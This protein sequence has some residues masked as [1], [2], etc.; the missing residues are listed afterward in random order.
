VKKVGLILI[1][2]LIVFT[3]NTFSRTTENS[4][5]AVSQEHVQERETHDEAEEH[6]E[7]IVHI[8]TR[9]VLQLVLIL[10]AAKIA[11]E[12]CERYLKQPGVLGELIAGMIIG[13][14]VLGSKIIIPGLGALFASPQ[15]GVTIPVSNELYALGQIAVIILLFMAGL[16]TDFKQFFKYAGPATVVAIGGV[17]F[18]FV[19]GAAATIFFIHDIH[20]ITHPEALFVG[21]IMVATSVGIT[22]RILS[23]IN[24][25]DT[26]EGVTI[27][28]GAVVDDVL[29][30][31]ILAI[32]VGVS[33]GEGGITGGT[34]ALIAIKAVGIWIGI[35][36]MG[37][38]LSKQIERFLLWF[39]NEGALLALGLAFC[40]LAAGIAELFGL[41]AIIGSYA[42]GLAL[43]EREIS[44]R[45][46]K[47]LTP[48]FDFLVPV[49]FVVM[50]MLV[51]FS[52][53]THAILF[54]IVLSTLA[55]LSKIFGCGLPAMAVGFNRIGATRIGIG[56][57]PRGEVALIVAGVGLANKV[58]Q[59]DIFGVAVMMTMIT[60]LLAPIFLVPSFQKGGSGLRKE[61]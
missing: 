31:L 10:T 2:L 59:T 16:E 45:L 22:A 3:L 11:G 13:P 5:H 48:V 24:K 47:A 8:V 61:N 39:K 12:I 7:N 19:L 29:G 49:F 58:I 53:M 54:G 40:F 55:V 23:D 15:P 30:I 26:P 34:I 6:E 44:H 25:L 42:M 20:S 21:A 9:L 56:M 36:G 41:A 50:G 46:E 38:L 35:T 60:T 51:D 4:S 37:L 52:S 27:L 14:Y 17:V 18:P 28:A 33:R 1:A 57:L 43:S 32:V